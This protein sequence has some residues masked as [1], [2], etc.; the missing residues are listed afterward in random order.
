MDQKEEN[1]T[2]NLILHNSRN[3]SVGDSRYSSSLI[4][5]KKPSIKSKLFKYS[6]Y[7]K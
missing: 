6:K 5:I 4:T 1:K 2:K 7:K 3:P